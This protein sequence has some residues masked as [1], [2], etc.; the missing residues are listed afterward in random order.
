VSRTTKVWGE[1][2]ARCRALARTEQQ[3]AN[4]ER[5]F[6]EL[7]GGT[8]AELVGKYL[9]YK[10]ATDGRY[11]AAYEEAIAAGHGKALTAVLSGTKGEG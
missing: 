8:G 11:R 6:L 10:I 1:F 9:S 5:A 2:Q 3:R 7:C 4:S